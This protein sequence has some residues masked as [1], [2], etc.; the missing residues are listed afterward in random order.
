MQT[1]KAPDIPFLAF[2]ALLEFL[3]LRGELATCLWVERQI[4]AVMGFKK[5]FL[6]APHLRSPG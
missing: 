6:A 5:Q 1:P 2:G 4:T 3:E